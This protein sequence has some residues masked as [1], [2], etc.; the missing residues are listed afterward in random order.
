MEE[1]AKLINPDRF[2]EEGEKVY[3]TFKEDLEKKYKGKIVAIE[4]ESRD[5]FL[6]DNEHDAIRKAE[7]KYPTKVFYIVRIGYPVVHIFR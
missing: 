5:Y 3:Q 2:A 1:L 7:E 4:I 6:G